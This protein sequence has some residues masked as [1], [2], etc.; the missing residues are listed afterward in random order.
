MHA[1]LDLSLNDSVSRQLPVFAELCVTRLQVL[2]FFDGLAFVCC[3]PRTNEKQVC[4][5]QLGS[6]LGMEKVQLAN[7]SLEHAKR[8]PSRAC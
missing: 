3:E 8:E 5:N 2:H 7:D 6:T 1:L 4:Q